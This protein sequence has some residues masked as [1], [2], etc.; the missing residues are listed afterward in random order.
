MV[1]VDD[2]GERAIREQTSSVAGT[3]SIGSGGRLTE[4][5]QEVEPLLV[6]RSTNKGE[7]L[8]KT[9]ARFIIHRNPGMQRVN[10]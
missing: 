6:R 4:S 9:F 1:V 10:R 3:Q 5:E 8:G 2:R 7:V